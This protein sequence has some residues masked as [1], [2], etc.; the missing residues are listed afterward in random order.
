MTS[1]TEINDSQQPALVLLQKLGWQYITPEQTI[2]E[3]SEILS[4]VVLEN[5][6][7]Q[8]LYK[9]NSYEYKGSTYKFS[10]GNVHD[11]IYTLKNLPDEGLVKTSE[12]I[13][14]L[15]NLGKSFEENVHGD[16]KS[17]TIKYIDWENFDN[18]VFHVTDEFVVQGLTET[19]RPDLVLFINGIPFVVIENK[20]RDKKDS[21]KEAI[22]QFIRNQKKEDGIPKLFQFAQLLIATQPNEVMYGTT[23]TPAKF[24][25]LW[26]EQNNIEKEVQKILNSTI[27]RQNSQDRLPTEQD[28]MLYCLCR[29]NRVLE[30]T[31]KFIVFDG[32]VKK[33]ARYQ[34]YFA[35]KNALTRVSEFDKEEKRKGGVIW[36][37]QGSGKSLTMVMLAKS[38][39][40]DNK[41][42]NARIIVVTDRI[43]LDKQIFDTFQKCGKQPVRANSGNHLIEI[44][45]ESNVEIVTTI[46]DKFETALK[47][48]D[49]RNKSENIFV[50]VDESHRSQY[51]KN[52][53][54][55]KK[56]L[57]RACYIGFTGTP[58]MKDEKNT[59]NK[60]GGYIDKYT[61]DQAVSDGAVLPLLYEGR[62]AKLTV[63]QEQINRAFD[64][65][66][67]PLNEYQAKDLKQKFSSIT[68]I[69]KSQQVIEEIA[70]DISEHYCKNWKGTGFKAI[71]AVPLKDTA[72][73][74][75]AY[76]EKQ[77]NPKL[78]I[79]TAVI[80]S[81]SD[82]RLDHEEVEDEVTNEVQQYFKKINQRHGSIEAYEE[83][84]TNKFKESDDEIELLI[85]VG[86]LLTGFDAPRCNTLYIA[87]P[88]KEHGLLQ[89]IARANRLY[90]GKDYG[91]IVDYVGVLGDLD[92]AL[93]QYSALEEFDESD[94]ASAIIKIDEEIKKIPQYHSELW[95]VFKTVKNKKDI[96]EMGRFLAPKDIRDTFRE[97][98][99]VFA[100]SL[101]AGMAS[102]V[103]YKLFNEERQLNFTRDLKFFQSLRTAVQLRYSEKIDY[104]EY[105]GRV[106]KLLDMQIGVDGIEQTSEPI[107]I[108]NEELFKKEVE[109]L[110]G[111]VASKADTIAYRMKKVIT[112]KMDEDPIFYK[113]F[114]KLI[115]EAIQA[116]IDKRLTEAE[117]LKQMLEARKNLVEGSFSDV[118]GNL[119]GNPEARAFYGIVKEV[120]STEMP[121]SNL[122]QMNEQLAQA[123][124]DLSNT[125]QR[126]VIRD[127]KKNEDVQKQMK[128]DVEDYLL[129]KRKDFG[130]ELSFTQL[131][132][133]LDEVLKV[134]QNVF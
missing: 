89:A 24:W 69:Y 82:T 125:L 21:T 17:F 133:I 37:T 20:R 32:K 74:Y 28:R 40:L 46:I 27:N 41:I 96:E 3:R 56:V 33:V 4:N 51:G 62:S 11:A 127:W 124:I 113:K 52:H 105:E 43:E 8:Q 64:R 26:K 92:K 79:D 76:F 83:S 72:L 73:K 54:L 123:G 6:L 91:H 10:Q 34:Q 132:K 112:E 107:N 23:N 19:R 1:Y 128:N 67:E 68:E 49:F 93:T 75:Q 66:S 70:F 108:F 39:I 7:E 71:L 117:Y 81:A 59:A 80:I 97:K 94:I 16:K 130:V 35:V 61:I 126:L 134:A 30:L 115:D 25:G 103:Y 106:R 12:K 118:P 78:K 121:E 42:K 114:G 5:I 104:K 85:V 63:N 38:I 122:L 60:F 44:V 55:M 14:D 100:K 109:R 31:Y 77:T 102:D 15:I 131:D 87:K 88:L 53:A 36:H 84:V 119:K 111:S 50:L 110:T 95:D 18:N 9:I 65:L 45:Q 13:Y 98:L 57:P 129:A 47:R 22:S 2:I 48:K 116:F 99:I 29:P 120:L 58:L 101:Q 86:K 90:Q